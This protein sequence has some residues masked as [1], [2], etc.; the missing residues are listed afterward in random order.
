MTAANCVQKFVPIFDRQSLQ[1]QL[2]CPRHFH[3]P[4]EACAGRIVGGA[5]RV[6]QTLQK[7]I[8]LLLLDVG[9][10][11]RVPNIGMGVRQHI[12]RQ[13]LD[14]FDGDLG[15]RD[16]FAGHFDANSQFAHLI[17]GRYLELEFLRTVVQLKWPRLLTVQASHCLQRLGIGIVDGHVQ[18]MPEPAFAATQDW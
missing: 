7:I 9:L 2:G 17:G 12:D 6:R 10:N 13:F 8:D 4:D 18:R 1:E 14:R 11:G 5:P 15:R 16:R 3:I